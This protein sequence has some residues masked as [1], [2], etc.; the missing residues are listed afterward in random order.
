M[1]E[2]TDDRTVFER[3]MAIRSRLP[4][5]SYAKKSQHVADL[6]AIAGSFDA[7]IFDS[8]GVLNVGGGAIAGAT[9]RIA[10]LRGMGKCVLVLTNAATDPLG[11]LVGK[12]RKLGFDFGAAEIISS[13]RLLERALAE[14]PRMERWGVAAP[15]ASCIGEL[16]VAAE[17]LDPG[18][19]A[20]L[21]GIILLSSAEWNADRQAALIAALRQTPRP[22]WVGNP[23]LAAPRSAGFSIEPGWYAHHVWDETGIAPVFFGKPYGQAFD[24]VR[25]L[26]PPGCQD[27]RVLMLG[28][29]LHT[30]ILG[31]RAAGF[32]T[33]LVS[34]HGVLKNL[35]I[36]E[37][38]SRAGI[39]PDVIMPSI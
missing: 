7:F 19:M 29:T 39:V 16:P 35:D 14:R 38:I 12:Y 20:G 8:F 15:A 26:L 37:A 11:S 9:E 30:D 31:A 33:A 24:A 6:G 32:R 10:A 2:M 17:P 25:Q 36:D 3:Y 21:A 23:D 4:T 5:A 18:V 1:V 34:G 27:D 22:V 13:R 28:D